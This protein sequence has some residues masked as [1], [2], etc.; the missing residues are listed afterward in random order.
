MV[1]LRL[2]IAAFV[3]VLAVLCV[4]GLPKLLRVVF[5]QDTS[6][7]VRTAALG[8]T[9]VIWSSSIRTTLKVLFNVAHL[10]FNFFWAAGVRDVRGASLV[11]GQSLSTVA[12]VLVDNL[13]R[14]PTFQLLLALVTLVLL[15][16]T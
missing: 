3:L 12:T 9:L 15:V 2:I 6:V 7:T 13:G 5:P 10:I 8:L 1:T 16:R 4:W 14:I 11:Q